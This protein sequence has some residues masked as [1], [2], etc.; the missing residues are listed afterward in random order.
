MTWDILISKHLLPQALSLELERKYPKLYAGSCRQMGL[1]VVTEKMIAKNLSNMALHIF[2]KD[3]TWFKV[4]SFYNLVSSAA[5]DCVRQGH[6]EYLYGLVE[7]AG[8]V[9][10]RD[11]AT[12]IANQG[13]WV[14]PVKNKLVRLVRLK[15]ERVEPSS[16]PQDVWK[17][18]R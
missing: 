17:V 10:E 7:A 3:I 13:G 2:K 4:A 8:L 16:Y 11:V 12:W 1:T 18:S 9:I 6:P 15:D 14:S 5:V